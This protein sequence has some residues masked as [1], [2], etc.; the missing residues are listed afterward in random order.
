MTL[1]FPVAGPVLSIEYAT[2]LFDDATVHRLLRHLLVLLEEALDRPGT[3][4]SGLPLLSPDQRR[5][6]LSAGTS[7]TS[8]AETRPEP[9]E[10]GVHLLFEE[11]ARRTPDAPAVSHRGEEWSYARLDE[12]ARRLAEGLRAN[13]VR[14]GDRVGICLPRGPLVYV[15]VLAVWKVGAAYVPLDPQYP[16]ERLRYMFTD[17]GARALLTDGQSGFVPPDGTPV[18]RYTGET[19]GDR[20]S[21]QPAMVEVT[22]EDAAYV[23]YTSGTTGRP[24]GVTVFTDLFRCG[25]SDGHVTSRSLTNSPGIGLT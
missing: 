25:A 19:G 13:D 16:Q 9:S 8:G 18:V 11:H 10:G 21:A 17:S 23:L 6:I 15:A 14:R 12:E 20:L 7:G 1:N 5:E 4:I 3:A 22:A 24:K 2:E